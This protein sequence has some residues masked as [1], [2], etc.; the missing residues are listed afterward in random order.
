MLFSSVEHHC[1]FAE[2]L[3]MVEVHAEVPKDQVKKVVK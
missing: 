2:V 1:N 3:L